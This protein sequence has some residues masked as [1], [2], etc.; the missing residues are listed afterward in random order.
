M[1]FVLYT[2]FLPTASEWGI[3]T[4]ELQ[5]NSTGNYVAVPNATS[6]PNNLILTNLAKAE[7]RHFALILDHIT[8]SFLISVINFAFLTMFVR[9]IGLNI[10]ESI[11]SNGK[12]IVKMHVYVEWAMGSLISGI[13]YFSS[14]IAGSTSTYTIL[15]MSVIVVF[16]VIS[17]YVLY[18]L[19]KNLKEETETEK[20]KVKQEAESSK[21]EERENLLHI[22][23]GKLAIYLILASLL[24]AGIVALIGFLIS[25]KF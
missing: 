9:N 6:F 10:E 5:K 8:G 24:G 13:L 7:E 4:G 25:S 19:R 14:L 1:A 3:A 20:S 21:K 11:E 23:C 16:A 18:G 2:L 22:S 15:Y 12:G 17:T